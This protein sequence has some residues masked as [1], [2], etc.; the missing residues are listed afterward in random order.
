MFGFKNFGKLV[1]IDNTFNGLF[2]LL[3]LPFT[4]WGL[5]GLRGNF[6]WINII[7]VGVPQSIPS[8]AVNGS[9]GYDI[10]CGDE[11]I[12]SQLGS[13]GRPAIE[14]RASKSQTYCHNSQ[15]VVGT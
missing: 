13:E 10:V 3:Q 4:N 14:L 12:V 7:Q 6:T 9:Q 11:G 8:R 2:G 5:H 15:H 1:A